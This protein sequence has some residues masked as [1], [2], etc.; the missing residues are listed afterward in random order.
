MTDFEREYGSDDAVTTQRRR[1][2]HILDITTTNL[3]L[4]VVIF[5]LIMG[6]GITNKN[7]CP[8]QQQPTTTIGEQYLFL[9][10]Y[11]GQIVLLNGLGR[12]ASF[13]LLHAI[14]A[15]FLVASAEGQ[16][17][18]CLSPQ[19]LRPDKEDI[20]IEYNCIVVEACDKLVH[21]SK[22]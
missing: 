4:T 11:H 14:P 16:Q 22:K 6:F 19:Q 2:G 21:L 12:N 3:V 18:C 13:S 9:V 7:N 1:V 8:A 15:S 10:T 20:A 17:F 5:C